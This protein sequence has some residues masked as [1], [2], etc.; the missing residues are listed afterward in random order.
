MNETQNKIMLRVPNRDEISSIIKQFKNDYFSDSIDIDL[1]SDKYAKFA[2][3]IVAY[4]ENDP[5][6]Y[7]AYYCNDSK[8]LTAYITMVVV[9]ETFRCQGIATKMLDFVLNNCRRNGFKK[10]RLEVDNENKKA[11]RLYKKTGFVYEGSAGNN[12]SYYYI[13]LKNEE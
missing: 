9:K 4:Y 3:L 1:I 13:S 12:S 8:A 7:I 10:C 11:L 2:D 5:A 6:G